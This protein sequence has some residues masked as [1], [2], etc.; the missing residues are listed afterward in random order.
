M[1]IYI[2]LSLDIFG[3]INYSTYKYQNNKETK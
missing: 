2:E 1:Q 3:I